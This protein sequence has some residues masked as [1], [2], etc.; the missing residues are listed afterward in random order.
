[1]SFTWA[2]FWTPIARVKVH[3]ANYCTTWKRHT[4]VVLQFQKYLFPWKHCQQNYMQK[5]AFQQNF[6]L[7]YR[8]T[9]LRVKFCSSRISMFHLCSSFTDYTYPSCCTVAMH[10]HC[11][12]W[13]L[14][15]WG[16]SLPLV[17]PWPWSPWRLCSGDGVLEMV[18]WLIATDAHIQMHRPQCT[19][20]DHRCRC[21][22]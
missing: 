13:V 6:F 22:M 10:T 7:Y 11:L 15:N 19:Y 12:T 1:M 2:W 4:M 16:Q 17:W 9:I 3:H 14:F 18:S 20:P 21:G 8:N 5:N